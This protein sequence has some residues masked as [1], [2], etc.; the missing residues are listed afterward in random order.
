MRTL[1]TGGL[2]SPP[3]LI[4][5]MPLCDEDQDYRNKKYFLCDPSL[6]MVTNISISILLPGWVLGPPKMTYLSK[7]QSSWHCLK[8]MHVY[9]AIFLLQF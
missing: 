4:Q 7:V 1:V 5:I 2:N 9:M 6:S 3:L 8:C